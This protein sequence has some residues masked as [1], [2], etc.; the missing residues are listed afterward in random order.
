MSISFRGP[1]SPAEVTQYLQR[2]VYPMRLACVGGDGY[3][4]VVSVWYQYV[5]GRFYSVSHR[6]SK[7]VGLLQANGRVGFEIAPNEPPYCGVRGQG[8]AEVVEL[9]NESTLDKLLE[10]YLGGTE[11]RLGN[12]LLSRRD[13]EMLIT[14]QP[15]RMFSWDYQE[16]MEDI[17]VPTAG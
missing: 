9:G 17:A 14:V 4:R 10:R 5:E 7:L 12:W 8:L 2:C 13:E 11:S 15:R 16:R 6:E 1:W 3:P